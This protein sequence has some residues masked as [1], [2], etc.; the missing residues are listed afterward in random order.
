MLL[1]AF[2]RTKDEMKQL[3][4]WLRCLLGV[5]VFWDHG[6]VDGSRDSPPPPVPVFP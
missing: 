3:N 1:Y 6:V 5:E 4:K 2:L